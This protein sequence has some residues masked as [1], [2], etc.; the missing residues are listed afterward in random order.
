MTIFRIFFMSENGF[1]LITHLFKTS[2]AP[3]PVATPTKTGMPRRSKGSKHGVMFFIFSGPIFF[4]RAR[5]FLSG[6][7]FFIVILDVSGF[8]TVT[9]RS[10][11]KNPIQ[12]T[13]FYLQ[14]RSGARVMTCFVFAFFPQTMLHQNSQASMY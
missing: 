11:V 7:T 3:S 12:R 6:P 4:G 5:V 2:W 8:K 10:G 14:R 1:L 9:I 13:T